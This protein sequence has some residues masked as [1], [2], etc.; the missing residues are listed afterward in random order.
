MLASLKFV[1]RF[2]SLPKKKTEWCVLEKKGTRLVYDI[3]LLG[4]LLTRQGFEVESVTH[5]GEGFDLVVVGRIESAVPH[6]KADR[7]Q[8]CLVNVGEGKLRQ[9]VCGAKNA[10]PELFVAVALPGAK[11]PGDLEIKESAI[12]DV[13]SKGMLCSRSELGLPLSTDLDGDGIWELNLEAQG[14]TSSEILEKGLG[15]PV[16][17]VLN[18]RDTLLELN[19]TPNRPDML[20][21]AGVASEIA[22]GLQ[23]AGLEAERKS[24]SAARFAN[25]AGSGEVTL[26]TLVSEV[27]AQSSVATSVG[28]FRADNELG[29]SAFFVVLEN[30][31]VE[32]SPAWLRNLLEGLGQN[33]INYTVDVSNFVLLAYGQPSHA[34]DLDKLAKDANGSPCLTLRSAKAGE[35]FVGLDGKQRELVEQDCVVADATVPQALLGVIG[36]EHSKVDF[37]TRNIVLEF[38]NAHPVAVRRASRRHGRKTDSSFAFEKGIDTQARFAAALEILGLLSKQSSQKPTYKGAVGSQL[39]SANNA[40]VSNPVPRSALAK[41]FVDD[42]FLAQCLGPALNL[43]VCVDFSVGVSEPHL[44]ALAAAEWQAEFEKRRK[45]LTIRLHKDDQKKIVGAELVTFEKQIEILQAL[46]FGIQA[47]GSAQS[48]AAGSAQSVA[49]G[50]E[51]NSDEVLV[52]V[53]HWRWLDVAGVADLI[54]EIVRVV[55]IDQVPS[56]PLPGAG[57]VMKDDDHLAL[58]ERASARAA[59]LGYNEIAGFHFMRDTDVEKLGLAHGNALGEPVAMMNPIL[60]DE[61][62]M[63]TTLI[64]NLLRRVA[65]NES[66]GVKRGQLFH[67]SRTFQNLDSSGTR[68]FEDNGAGI[69]LGA[70]LMQKPESQNPGNAAPLYDYSSSASLAYSREKSQ[71]GR[72]TETPRLAGVVFGVREEKGW[73]N[74]SERLWDLHDVIAHGVEILRTAGVSAVVKSL[75]EEHP[76]APALHPGRRAAFV[77]VSNP[78]AGQNPGDQKDHDKFLGW[79]GAL[80]PSAARGFE[81]ESSCLVFELNLALAREV[82]LHAGDLKR[83]VVAPLRFPA[84]S[85]D[86]AFLLKEDVAAGALVTTVESALVP[87]VLHTSEASAKHLGVPAKLLGVRIFDVYR[88]KGVPEG[89]KS[90]AFNVTLEPLERTLNEGD[91]QK[92]ATAVINAVTTGLSGELRG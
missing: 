31:K 1:E 3:P 24:E 79:V 84:V 55:G 15:Q 74:A 83:R 61:P 71:A 57:G 8:I 35:K 60:K 62:L 36:G 11:L 43:G 53:P 33:S 41:A 13:E 27:A 85:R 18:L 63:H 52:V 72:P 91:I 4:L 82:S 51:H 48:V 14:G 88:G 25:F 87:G 75:P 89:F 7:L 58:L 39:K 12:R 92:I 59:A 67:L 19:V 49:A 40:S 90:V 32:K 56:I 66:F 22:V 64:P 16:F 23:Y 5:R 20:C 65:R 50:S 86:F 81:V 2:L 6:P 17:D 9:I 10:R 34:F 37:N 44:K 54:E 68:V 21:H 28:I 78:N 29:V 38:A 70:K 46:G 45:K 30:V 26:E 73:Q 47:A 42:E 69:G 80:H 77:A 76:M